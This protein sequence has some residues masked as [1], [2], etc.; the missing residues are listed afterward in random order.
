MKIYNKLIRDKIPEVMDKKGLIYK[1]RVLTPQEYLIALK[2]KLDEEVAEYKKDENL[3]EL[4]DIVEVVD[5]LA[6][7]LGG[8]F[9]DVLKIKARKVLERG[10]FEK[11]L[12][13]EYVNE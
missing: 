6:Q 13:L 9:D 5:H 2:T 1:T 8:N 4:A 12:F 7:A 11:R 3:E 10:G